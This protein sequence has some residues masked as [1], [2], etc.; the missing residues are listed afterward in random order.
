MV[1]LI[2]VAGI[3]SWRTVYSPHPEYSGTVILPGLD[4]EVT[5]YHDEYAI[6]HIVA[7]SERDLFFAQGY[8]T[9]RERMFQM[10][11]TRRAGRGE[12]SV[13]FGEKTLG[14]DRYLKT[15]GLYREAK[16]GYAA[17]GNRARNILQAY[18]DG[19]NA[20]I[21]KAS[22]LPFEYRVLRT[23]PEEWKPEDSVAVALLMSY[24]LTRSKKVDL[25][26]HRLGTQR[27]RELLELLSPSYPEEAP[28]LTGSPVRSSSQS[29]TL[30]HLYPEKG[31]DSDEKNAKIPSIP[32]K[33]T[34]SN[35]MIFS[36]DR[37]VS[38]KPLFAGSPDLAPTLPS[39]FY[40]THLVCEKA[41]IDVMGGALPGTPAIGPLG[42]N[43]H[44]AWSAVNGRGDEMDY[45]IEKV[46]PDDPSEYRTEEGFR[47]F[48][49]IVETLKIKNGATIRE[50]PLEVKISRHGPVISPV[51]EG[52]PDNMAMQ[53]AAHRV[54]V[55]DI[56]G[57]IEM[58]RARNFTEFRKA[59][60]KVRT[61]N[62]GLGYADKEGNIGWQFLASPPVRKKGDG[63]VP[64]PGWTGE[65][66]WSGFIPYEK[67]PYD[68]N[69]S[70]GW[71]A[72]FNN[73]P[74]TTNAH[75][76]NFYLFRRAMRF[77]EI[78]R[79]YDGKK[80]EYDDI[81]KLQLD[82]VS[83]TAEE[84]VPRILAVIEG[85]GELQ[86]E[87]TLLQQWDR[88]FDRESSA[89]TLFGAFYARMMENTL[90]DDTGEKLWKEF[91]QSYLHYIPD[92]ALLRYGNIPDHH[93]YDDRTT[94]E[95]K[96]TRDDIILRSMNEAV[97]YLNEELGDS[98]DSWKWGDVHRMPFTHQLGS[99]LGFLN[100]D[101]FP[102]H[103]SHE[104]I[105]AGF[106]SIQNPFTMEMGGVIR[107]IVDFGEPD[108]ST[109]ISPPGQSGHFGSDHYGDLAEI[110]ADGDQI[111][112][113]FTSYPQ[114][115]RKLILQ[116]VK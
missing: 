95:K 25:A 100:L 65:Y 67:I 47:K 13:L 24:S 87:Y 93:L 86:E 42:Y 55:T 36:G 89:A 50:E 56:E 8:I 88:R 112:M 77:E 4:S 26:L 62:L 40:V 48:E 1:L 85:S 70:K 111:P 14:K 17:M 94:P 102:T 5:I 21:E 68:I 107:I 38:G 16:K 34:S 63:T 115:D 53:W 58:N 69:P 66:E 73:D 90:F 74:G 12:L 104:T 41:G 81:L 109:I 7:D 49:T 92:L 114:L 91:S 106:W 83:V 78:M 29:N 51:V 3:F 96:E 57:L 60:K 28:S 30:F 2:L 23:T 110:W 27:G 45:F 99:A 37:T 33:F 15:I 80:F 32:M 98:I 75:L 61:I 11:V 84:W 72:S 44:I 18:T 9:A 31:T 116:P 79:K 10:D 19:V 54:P 43:G 35:W 39:L 108:K 6:P 82:T 59:L 22:A 46:N 97:V 71:V 52:V 113:Q 103:G 20:Y 64:V 105:N 101:E 76:S